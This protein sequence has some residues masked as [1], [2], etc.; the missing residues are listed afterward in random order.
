LEYAGGG[1]TVKADSPL[2]EIFAL[3][4][5][6][7]IIPSGYWYEFLGVSAPRFPFRPLWLQAPPEDEEH[8][9][10]VCK[11]VVELGYNAVAWEGSCFFS[12]PSL[13][14]LKS[15]CMHG[16]KGADFLLCKSSVDVVL[17]EQTFLDVLVQEMKN[18]ERSL[19][20]GQRLIYVLPSRWEY[21]QQQWDRLLL[22]ISRE[23]QPG[24]CLGFS[25]VQGEPFQGHFQQHPFWSTL[26]GIPQLQEANLLP[27]FHVGHS[28]Q[29]GG[30]WPFVDFDQVDTMLNDCRRH[31]FA[32]GMVMTSHMP[33]KGGFLDANLWVM[34]QAMWRGIAS[35]HLLDIWLI[36][37]KGERLDADMKCYLL[38]V[39]DIVKTLNKLQV[40]AEDA[41]AADEVRY[42][43]ELG[44]LHLQ[45]LEKKALEMEKKRKGRRFE[46]AS[47]IDYLWLFTT[48]AR[49][50]LMQMVPGMRNS[51]DQVGNVGQNP[52]FNLIYEENGKL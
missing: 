49:Q 28:L 26:P 46:S 11:R 4:F 34:A 42:L 18:F 52:R 36:A 33:P 30:G 25:W 14:G 2:G 29:G 9:H 5:L 19:L 13:Y 51:G 32:G 6:C 20:K 27:I 39:K 43:G 40:P 50:L 35:M 38:K 1:L 15:I 7:E 8:A 10:Q 44:L 16:E 48:E 22:T 17:V 41:L 37:N 45:W 23:S 21:S 3:S 47:F 24:T 31:D 12:I